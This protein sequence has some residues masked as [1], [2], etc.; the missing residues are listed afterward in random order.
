MGEEKEERA[1]AGLTQWHPFRNLRRRDD[2]FDDFFRE[3]FRR[4]DVEVD[5][6][7]PAAEVAESEQD[8]TVKMQ[9]P[10]V[11]KDQLHVTI[12]DDEVSVRGEVRKETE[13]KKKNY[14]RQEIRYGAFQR[15]VALPAEVD[16]EKA[17]AELK[18]GMLKI[19]LPKSTRARARKIEVAVG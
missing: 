15:T 16:G 3:F 5:V 6:M 19:V 4:G 18:D 2:L 17:K 14:Y 9:V 10:G 12:G 1:M 8:V 11:T 13:E 7:E